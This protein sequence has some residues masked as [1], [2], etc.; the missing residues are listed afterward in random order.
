MRWDC[1]TDVALKLQ[2]DRVTPLGGSRGTFINVQ[3]G[4]RSG[5]SVNVAS[6]VLDFVF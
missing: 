5:R 1:T 6:A 2:F 4:F 3:P